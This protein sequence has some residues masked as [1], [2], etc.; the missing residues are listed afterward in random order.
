MRL[1]N[2]A[3]GKLIAQN[4]RITGEDRGMRGSG[5]GVVVAVAVNAATTKSQEHLAEKLAV[6]FTQNVKTWLSPR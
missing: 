3:T 6:S 1:E 4:P 5:L 2:A